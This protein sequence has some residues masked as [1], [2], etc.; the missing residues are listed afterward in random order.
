MKTIRLKFH[1]AHGIPPEGTLDIN[2]IATLSGI[3]EEALKAV[4]R[5]ATTPKEGKKDDPFK[6]KSKRITKKKPT[7]NPEAFSIPTVGK[8]KGWN[9]VYS[10]AMK[11]WGKNT[12][13]AMMFG[14]EVEVEAPPVEVSEAPEP[15]TEFESLLLEPELSD[16]CPGSFLTSSHT[17]YS[18]SSYDSE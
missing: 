9:G 7:T 2:Q 17:D 3:P 1:E 13:I 14:L 5:R 18:D 4:Y 11:K 15:P 16:L 8:G 6:P 12:D 10:F